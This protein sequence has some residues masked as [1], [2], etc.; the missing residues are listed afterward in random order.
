MT[1]LLIGLLIIALAGILGFYGTQL[2]RGGWTEVFPPP[3]A[4]ESTATRSYVIVASTNL[5]IPAE[6]DKP[7][8]ITF[9][10]RNTGQTHASGSFRDFTYYFST[11]PEK[12]EFAYQHSDAIS[13]SESSNYLDPHELRDKSFLPNCR[14]SS[15][16]PNLM[17]RIKSP[18]KL[19]RTLTCLCD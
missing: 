14:H 19:A 7:I 17:G 10:L 9:D 11:L 18:C 6:P 13:F 16:R 15:N 12:K 4:I 5:L 8:Q 1:Q 3:P 2:A